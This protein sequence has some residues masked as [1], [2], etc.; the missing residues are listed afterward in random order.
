MSALRAQGA[1]RAVGAFCGCYRAYRQVERCWR[2][3]TR[4]GLSFGGTIRRGQSAA[5]VAVSMPNM[6][7]AGTRSLSEVLRKRGPTWRPPN[8]ARRRGAKAIGPLARHRFSTRLDGSDALGK[9]LPAMPPAPR[10]RPGGE[11]RLLH[12]DRAARASR[13]DDRLV[14][15]HS[16][17]RWRPGFDGDLL[18]GAVHKVGRGGYPARPHPVPNGSW[19][20]CTSEHAS[21]PTTH[22]SQPP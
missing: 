22:A 5:A 17:A 14:A 18:A 15:T 7:W 16:T 1:V 9:V 6:R 13:C 11:G 20:G 10:L 19:F 2:R 8:K 4:T 21:A 3:T 12:F